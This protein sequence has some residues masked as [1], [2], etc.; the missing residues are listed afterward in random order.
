MD[1]VLNFITANWEALLAI[2]AIDIILSGDNAVVIA[3][4]A[5][6]L[7]KEQQ[8]KAVFLG[9][10]G[11]IALRILFAAIVV[12][13]IK[14]P[15]LQAVGGIL[16]LVVAYKLLAEEEGDA[17]V[18]AG[19]TLTGAVG[20]IIYSDA[21]MS[22]D[23][24]IAVAGVGHGDIILIAI[25]VLVSIPIILLGSAIILKAIEKF[26][27]IT[28]IGSGILAWTATGMMVHDRILSKYIPTTVGTIACIV[29]TI[30]VV[31]AG[32]IKNRKAANE[33]ERAA[34]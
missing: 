11:A 16:L 1:A 18:K 21:L 20:T 32:W 6:L 15:F 14:I 12:W 10:F 17:N 9:T 8:K 27:I 34:A 30:G 2:I 7:P 25:G 26:P 13:L 5:R 33:Q 29:V 19:T 28:Y 31:L 24:V 4:A 23:N 3:M 22:L